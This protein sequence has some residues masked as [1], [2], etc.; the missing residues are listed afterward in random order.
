[1]RRFIRVVGMMV[2]VL[3]ILHGIVTPTHGVA[4][5]LEPVEKESPLALLTMTPSRTA[6]PTATGT[7]TRTPG[8]INWLYLPLSQR[9][10][11]PLP[12]P[13]ATRTPSATATVRPSGQEQNEQTIANLINSQRTANG[14]ATEQWTSTL[15]FAARRHSND[16][17][18]H[19]LES[20]TGSDGSTAWQRM[21]AAGYEGEGWAEIIGWG[22]GGNPTRMMDWWMNSSIHRSIILSGNLDDFGV[23]YVYYPGS[24]WGHY[25][26]VDFGRSGPLLNAN[27]DAIHVC[28]FTEA[29]EEG[30]AMLIMR[31]DAP[32]EA[33]TP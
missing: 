6:S 7:P 18:S 31:T 15:M 21:Q 30:G 12:T 5:P 13:T 16:M 19:N 33:L 1:M 32:C 25:W 26:T 2:V 17:A 22:F 14:L 3:G 27:P 9:G 20:H 10:A 4:A 23:G 11:A 28:T 29:G 8:F 24:A